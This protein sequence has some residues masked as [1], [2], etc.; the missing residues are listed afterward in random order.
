M[1]KVKTKSLNSHFSTSGSEEEKRKKKIKKVFWFLLC[2]LENLW[3]SH[4][5]LDWSWGRH[6]CS[7]A[8]CYQN[9]SWTS[10]ISIS[11]LYQLFQALF[12]K[13]FRYTFLNLYYFSIKMAEIMN[14]FVSDVPSPFMWLFF[15]INCSLDLYMILLTNQRDG[16][17][18]QLSLD[19]WSLVKY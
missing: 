14:E 12:V 5:F 6:C 11:A 1:K 15:L 13:Y 3:V 8:V 18:F 17:P 19:R 10:F 16:C 9:R 7:S 4:L 2:Y